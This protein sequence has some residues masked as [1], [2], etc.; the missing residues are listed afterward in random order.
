MKLSIRGRVLLIAWGPAALISIALAVYFVSTNLSALRNSRRN[1][2]LTLSQQ[3][4]PASQYGVL[5][6]NR[7]ILDRLIHS[8]LTH[9]AVS[10]VAIA[11]RTGRML[12]R[13]RRPESQRS[14][15][16][17]SAT[18]LINLLSR[19]SPQHWVF[20]SPIVLRQLRLNPN[21]GLF[22]KLLKP[23]RL[24]E[25]T[26]G[27]IRLTLSTRHVSEQ[28]SR[29]I[30]EGLLL[31]LT[32]LIATF[33]LAARMSR[34]ITAPLVQMLRSVKKLA[35]GTMSVRL[36]QHS[37][38]E[39]G[40][41][42]QGINQ[43]A[44]QIEQSTNQLEA[45]VEQ[46]TQEL[47]ETLEAV[48]IKN[49]A[50]DLA[51]KQAVAAN[52][53][54]T[55]F[56]ANINHEI[57][58]PMNTILGYVDFLAGTSLDTDQ[59]EY[60]TL[61]QR[62]SQNLLEL[63]DQ[64]LRLSRIEAGHLDLLQ[65]PCNIQVVLEDVIAMLAPYAWQKGLD[66]LPDL[67]DECSPMVLADAGKLR[68][69]FNNLIGNAIKF[70]EHG[71]VRVMM[72]QK[73]EPSAT[74]FEFIVEDSGVGLSSRDLNR[75]F[76]PFTQADASSSRVQGGVGLGL[77]ICRR[78][79]EAMKGTIR[80]ESE[81]ERGSRFIVELAFPND[82]RPGPDSETAPRLSGVI[83]LEAPELFQERFV[84][85]FHQWGLRVHSTRLPEPLSRETGTLPIAT[86]SIVNIASVQEILAGV[87]PEQV[88]PISGKHLILAASADRRQLRKI[89]RVLKG[90]AVSMHTP[91]R[92]LH[93]NLSKLLDPGA[94]TPEDPELSDLLSRELP[95]QIAALKGAW[96]SGNRDVVREAL[97]QLDGTA[98]FLKLTALKDALVRLR[99]LM[100]QSDHNLNLS[101]ADWTQLEAT[102]ME[103][104]SKPV[105]PD[106]VEPRNNG[107]ATSPVS[108]LSG[109]RILLA[110]DNAVNRTLLTRMLIHQGAEVTACSN[111]EA[112]LQEIEQG[113]W[114]LVL[115][116]IHMPNLDGI[117]SARA[118]SE[119]HPNLPLIAISADI[120]SESRLEAMNAGIR[121]YLIKPIREVDLTRSIQNV[122][123][124]PV[125][126]SMQPQ[127]PTPDPKH[128]PD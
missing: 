104:L 14:F 118:I 77:A 17:E 51:R 34:S 117:Q 123:N 50:L 40:Q 7:T 2:G 112:L 35:Q 76:E 65:E 57:R 22:Q 67:Y 25:Q 20:Q 101:T 54:K 95:I 16:E 116:D 24:P 56:L 111:G 74:E 96:G 86:I 49:V 78:L 11:T 55:D 66:M 93:L 38:G 23:N 37:S 3:L 120:L 99:N 18:Y 85:L 52:R 21:H 110:E 90:H 103:I 42:E 75:I 126:R 13:G 106:T 5:T 94:H 109:I 105:H 41:L 61:I 46:A 121:D 87:I 30:L 70:T 115:L 128:P 72:R 4:A 62:S 97:H 64:V 81:P 100:D 125:T 108:G 83:R 36:N 9:S 47:R 69:I 28:E 29:I 6:R 12:V 89:G 107:P 127:T 91:R 82:S 73:S 113:C 119:R 98:R 88:Q 39:L 10:E 27:F 8:T 114:D 43:L 58:T 60:L 32:G 48:E 45:D 84:R 31:M 79:I 59:R 63:I 53:A 80:V 1:L 44:A 19:P 26:I 102:V 124:R 71:L 122:L 92:E 15:A 33:I 68:Q